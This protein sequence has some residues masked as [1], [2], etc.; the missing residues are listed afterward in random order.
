M[1]G[2]VITI[3]LFMN[4]KSN[5]ILEN[6]R[7]KKKKLI[8]RRNMRKRMIAVTAVFAIVIPLIG[9]QASQ[10]VATKFTTAQ[11]K[12]NE[13]LI[14][15]DKGVDLGYGPVGA[16]LAT[17][18]KRIGP[19]KYKSWKFSCQNQNMVD[20]WSRDFGNYCQKLLK[21]NGI[22]YIFNNAQGDATKEAQQMQD[23]VN[24]GVKTVILYPVYEPQAVPAVKATEKAGVRVVSMIPIYGGGNKVY[25]AKYPN[26]FNYGVLLANKI[27]A[28]YKAKGKSAVCVLSNLNFQFDALD[29]RVSGFMSVIGQYH[30]V[31]VKGDQNILALNQQEW[32]DKTVAMI[33][34]NPDVNCIFALYA[35]P[36]EGAMSAIAQTNT[37]DKIQLFT[38]DADQTILQGV[39]DGT[40]A[41]THPQDARQAVIWAVFQALRQLNGDKNVGPW[42]ES[43]AYQ[44][45]WIDTPSAAMQ[46]AKNTG[47]VL[48]G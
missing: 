22:P 21:D 18:L 5:I 27:A 16:D 38:I 46:Y 4:F 44:N 19:K 3:N 45:L 12:N 40:V 23:A 41:G 10:A 11:I 30:N 33:Q 24:Q 29:Q 25:G 43:K 7:T 36:A 8:E 15:P 34:K 37:K 13:D 20:P 28:Y 1:K 32:Q 47:L 6:I 17:L 42:I 9:L 26:Q 14:G 2:L 35:S 31:F 48:K 39:V